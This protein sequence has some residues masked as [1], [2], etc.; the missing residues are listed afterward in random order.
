MKA[1]EWA[2]WY[3]YSVIKD[4]WLEAEKSIMEDPEWA[5]RYVRNVIKDRWPEEYIMKD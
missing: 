4:R 3:A 2:Q 1:P 5:C